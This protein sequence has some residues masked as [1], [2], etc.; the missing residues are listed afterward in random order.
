MCGLAFVFDNGWNAA[1]ARQ[2]MKNALSALK[3][4]GPDDQG[5]WQRGS[6][7][8]GHRRLSIIDLG[9]ASHQP[10]A[11]PSGR[12]VLTYN[13]EVYNYRELRASLDSSWTFRT[14]GDTEV[15]LAGLITAGPAFLS[16]MEGMWALALWDDRA[17]TLLLARD[18][19][20]KKPLYYRRSTLGFACASELPALKSLASEPW[21]E[22]LD[23]TADYLRYGYYLPGTTAYS[24]I[25]ELLPGHYG[26]WS[27]GT[28]LVSTRFWS[29]SV[30]GYRGDKQHACEALHEE[31]RRSVAKR[32]IADVPVG[33]FLSGGIDSS[34][35]T[36][37]MSRDLG[38]TPETFTI[39]FA[40]RTFDERPY[41]RL[42]ASHFHTKH[43]EQALDSWD[44]RELTALVLRHVGQPFMDSSIL[45]TS[46]VSR[47]AAK[48]VKVALA[49]DGGDE[50]FSGYQ[51]YQARTV[52]RWYTRLPKPLRKLAEATVRWLPEP[53]AHHSGSILKKA[54]LF[55]DV[56]QRQQAETP[57]VAPTLYSNAALQ[58]L[59]PELYHRGHPPPLLPTEAGLDDIQQ[60]AAADA[61][62][63]LPQD[64]LTKV[65][66]ASMAYS[67]ETREP[68]LDHRVI[69]LAFSLPR[70]WHRSGF[71]GKRMLKQTFQEYLPDRIWQRRKQGFG[72]PIHSWFRAD[73]GD[74]LVE[75]LRSQRDLPFE[76]VEVIKLLDTHRRKSR[77]H[78][79]RLWGIYV[80]LLWK[81]CM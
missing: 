14:A 52:L 26:H 27:P 20:G 77:D 53:M 78:G 18:R 81:S 32:M 49:G 41:A 36:A 13:G 68:F 8:A 43:H 7:V 54:H 37:I 10:M 64:I 19:I 31:L 56:L 79:H 29:I 35:V 80:Y 16:R 66:R 51:R 11:D 72:V 24:S 50:L 38:L 47:L 58:A 46:M 30:G 57:Y 70:E 42:A 1:E 40:D 71:R 60:M 33:A 61:L 5:I 34:L 17:Q 73:L 3:H 9:S 23:S 44:R 39:G 59:A 48:H 25:R 69:E 12:F 6:T 62:V 63:Y 45:P 67:L 74:E 65:D 75:L 22:D 55:L 4:R 76:R 21:S 15:V 2:R 28:E